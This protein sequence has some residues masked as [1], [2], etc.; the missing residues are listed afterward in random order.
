MNEIFE[1]GK[2]INVH[3]I[4]GEVKIYPYTDNVELFSNLQYLIFNN[5]QNKIIS[6]RIHKKMV[7]A[8]FEDINDRNEAEKLINIPVFINR[9]DATP[10]EE[11]THYIQDLIGCIIYENNNILGEMVDIIKTGSN[12][13]YVVKTKKNDILI[14]ALKSVVKKIDID[15]KK[16]DVIL[17]EGLIDDEII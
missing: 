11:G 8:L 13:V 14:P 10:L 9:K 3:G 5:K 16:I 12:D 15:N 4:K 1:I 2:I 7:L 6:T 17:P